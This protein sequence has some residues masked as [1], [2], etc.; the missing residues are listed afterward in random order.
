MCIAIADF[1]ISLNAQIIRVQF[2]GRTLVKT[3]KT[4][5]EVRDACPARNE[6]SE[7]A[8]FRGSYCALRSASRHARMR[9]SHAA[10]ALDRCRLPAWPRLHV[11]RARHLL[12]ALSVGIRRYAGG[13]AAVPVRHHST[14]AFLRRRRSA[15]SAQLAAA[16]P[17]PAT[18]PHG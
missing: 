5:Y 14:S 15:H 9:E 10:A 7:K 2:S 3:N 6:F 17:S 4:G 16:D 13:R 12:L 1:R 8:L 18:L 11:S